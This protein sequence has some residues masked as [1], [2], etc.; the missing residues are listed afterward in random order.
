MTPQDQLDI[1]DLALIIARSHD[2]P[3]DYVVSADEVSENDDEFLTAIC[4][5][6]DVQDIV[7]GFK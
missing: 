2:L 7:D 6:A 3:L 4:A 5:S 1:R